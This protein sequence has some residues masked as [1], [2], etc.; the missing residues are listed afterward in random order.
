MIGHVIARGQHRA[1]RLQR[2]EDG[3]QLALRVGVN[4]EPGKG[5]LILG[6]ADLDLLHVEGAAHVHDG[7][8]GAWEGPGVDNVSFESDF[9]AE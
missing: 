6:A 9:F 2:R 4:L 8:K 1:E 3:L 5:N 7:V